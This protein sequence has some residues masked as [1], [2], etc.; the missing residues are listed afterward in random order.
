[1]KGGLD[2]TMKLMFYVNGRLVY[3]TKDIPKI[4]LHALNETEEKQEGVAYN[5]SLGGGT[6][7]LADTVQISNYMAEPDKVYPLEKYF[8]GSFIG[9]M[10]AFRF[11]NCPM[12]SGY[13]RNNYIYEVQNL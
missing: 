5:I 6:Q 11:Y 13:I 8:G 2:D 1:V 12:E 9:Y 10:T 3:V 4:P 7:G